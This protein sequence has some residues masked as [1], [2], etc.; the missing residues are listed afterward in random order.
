MFTL[1]PGPGEQP[2]HDAFGSDDKGQ[3]GRATVSFDT[4]PKTGDDTI[5]LRTDKSLYRVGQRAKLEILTTQRAGTVYLDFIKDRQTYLTA[6][7]RGQ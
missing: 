5:L 7:C 4:K 3:K 2:P 1:P 6:I